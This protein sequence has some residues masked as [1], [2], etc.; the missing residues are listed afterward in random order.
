MTHVLLAIE[1]SAACCGVALLVES[2]TAS[3]LFIREHVGVQEHSARLLPMVDEVLAEAGLA[4]NALTAVAFGQGPGGFTGLRVACGVAQGIAFAQGIPVV[5][6][7]SHEVIAAA[8]PALTHDRVLVLMDARM[9]EVYA[10]AYTRQADLQTWES[11]CPPVLMA[12]SSIPGWLMS[13]TD[14]AAPTWLAGD[15]CHVYPEAF[16]PSSRLR[17][18]QSQRPSVAVL[19]P[20]A[21][22]KLKQGQ[23]VAA[24]QAVPLYV[25]DKVA[26]TTEE[27]AAGAGGNPRAV[28]L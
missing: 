1:T 27:R 18:A 14:P 17:P 2:D 6:V 9:S 8:T 4:R 3:Q 21:L 26:F 13:Y 12:L 24:E 23:S 5:P 22:R 15:A 19:A 10:A 25:R 11:V 28:S 16:P 20:L 7:V